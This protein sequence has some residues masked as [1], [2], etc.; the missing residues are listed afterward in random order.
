MEHLGNEMAY[1][2]SIEREQPLTIDE[3]RTVVEMHPLIR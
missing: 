2:L 1:E 3:W